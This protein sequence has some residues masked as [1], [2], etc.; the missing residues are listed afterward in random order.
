MGKPLLIILYYVVVCVSARV[1][2][3]AKIFQKNVHAMQHEDGLPTTTVPTRAIEQT[4][5]PQ[6]EVN[7]SIQ[8]M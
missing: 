4:T 2:L 7:P 5:G 1:R 3:D 6:Q 8:P